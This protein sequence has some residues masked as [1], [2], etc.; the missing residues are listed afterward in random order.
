[1]DSVV[2]ESNSNPVAKTTGNA[3]NGSPAKKKLRILMIHGYCQ[4]S[5]IF[6]KK[7]GGFRKLLKSEVDFDFISAPHP[8]DFFNETEAKKEADPDSSEEVYAW[9]TTDETWLT[10]K[11]YIGVE[12]SIDKVAQHFEEKGPFDGIIGF[13]QGA[14]FASILCAVQAAIQSSDPN[15]VL[16]EEWKNIQFRFAIMVSGFAP[17]GLPYRN[18][19]ETYRDKLCPSMFTYGVG[20]PR[21]L[22]EWTKG[23]IK[24]FPE[25]SVVVEH[26]GGHYIPT[27]SDVKPALRS[28]VRG[29]L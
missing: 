27:T 29:F 10:T 9:W 2:H 23:M 22:P 16:K 28:F 25:S 14:V 12:E 6:E 18:L 19:L 15:V 21:V 3:R 7:S 24:L 17:T 11:K 5:N 8:V 4:N 20:D 26:K 13:S 1:M